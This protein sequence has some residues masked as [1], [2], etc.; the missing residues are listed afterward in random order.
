MWAASLFLATSSLVVRVTIVYR[1][2]RVIVFV[3]LCFCVFENDVM[4]YH[5]VPCHM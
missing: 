3:F 5:H 1:V 4:M 2:V